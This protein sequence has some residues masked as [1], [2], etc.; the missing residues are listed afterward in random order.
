MLVVDDEDAV[1]RLVCRMLAEAGF[2]VVEAHSGNEALALL[3]TLNGRVQLVL[4]D[5]AMP[6]MT[7]TQLAAILASRYPQTPVILMSGQGEPPADCPDHFLP[8]PFTP[9]ALLDAVGHLMP[10][11][12]Q[13]SRT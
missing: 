3:S 9:E 8:K 2:H 4:S 10:R 12:D 6:G 13:T 1:C 5:I 7:G 11:L